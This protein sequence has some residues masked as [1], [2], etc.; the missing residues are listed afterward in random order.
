MKSE[1]GEPLCLSERNEGA[2]SGWLV[3]E[4][5]THSTNYTFRG[6]S[7]LHGCKRT[8]GLKR[9]FFDF[10]SISNVKEGPMICLPLRGIFFFTS[11]ISLS[12]YTGAELSQ[13]IN[14]ADQV[15][16]KHEL[17]EGWSAEILN[18]RDCGIAELCLAY[19]S[20]A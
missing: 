11:A 16:S 5:A 19:R 20:E 1:V 7:T 9:Y 14:E 8:P 10:I 13:R 12:R 15:L 2:T 6:Y 17:T 18:P 4:Q 3:E